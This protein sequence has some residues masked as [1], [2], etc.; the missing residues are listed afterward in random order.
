MPINT[1]PVWNKIDPMEMLAGRF[2]NEIDIKDN[3]KVAV[4]GTNH[5]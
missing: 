5:D 4:I 1:Y 3:R 2:I